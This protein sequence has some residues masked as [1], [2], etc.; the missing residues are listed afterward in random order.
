MK[1]IISILLAVV[2]MFGVFT[3]DVFT[4][5]A[6]TLKISKTSKDIQPSLTQA[7]W[8]ATVFNIDFP[9]VKKNASAQKKEFIDKLDKLKIMGVNTV[10]VQVRPTADALYKSDINPWSNVLTGVQ[11]KDPGYD[12]MA[13]MIDETHKRGMTF[14]AWLNPY[15]ITTSGTDVKALCVNHPARLNTDWV[16]RYNNA[17][18]YNPE[19]EGVKSHIIN[20]VKEI[21]ENYKVDGIV[22]DDYFYPSNYP[23]PKGEGKDGIVANSRRENVNDMV[24]RVSAVIKS[25]KSDVVFGIS[26]MGIW[27]NKKSDP[28]GSDTM[29]NQSYYSVF[30]DAR[31]WIKNGWIDYISPQIYWETGNKAADYETLVKWWSNEV[32]GTKVKLYISHCLYKS[33]VAKQIDKQIKINQNYPEVSGSFYYNLKSLLTNSGGCRTKIGALNN[34]ISDETDK[35]IIP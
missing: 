5:D 3:S 19:K 8:I 28:A 11:G 13:F 32:K 26:P 34:M 29:G 7:V 33:I 2:L 17:L 16:I 14:Q 35:I 31:S 23:L 15:R 9:S 6:S 18:Y 22:F 12:P 20:T 1:K 4:A 25:T 27:K 10:I 24:A 30:A 21:V